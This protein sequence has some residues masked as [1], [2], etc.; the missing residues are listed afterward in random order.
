ML[1][2]LATAVTSV[3]LSAV[4][5]FAAS[6]EVCHRSG[7]SQYTDSTSTCVSSVLPPQ[8]RNTYGPGN[9]AS[10]DDR[11]GAWCEGVAGPGIG[12]TITLHQKPN[13]LIGSMSFVNGYARTPELYRANGRIKQARI[14]T[15]AGYKK[16]VDFADSSEHQFI[17]IS[18]HKVSW[19]RLTILAVYPGTR[20]S[21]TCATTFYLNQDDML[22][23]SPDNQEP[24]KKD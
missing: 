11:K 14:E 3:A 18:P 13:N 17:K 1:R 23:D 9:L 7:F 5:A 19:V 2:P 22:E 6:G 24:S 21:D 20:S 4:S 8:G 15:S 10:S 16:T 12:Q